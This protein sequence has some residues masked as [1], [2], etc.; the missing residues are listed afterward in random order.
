MPDRVV[1]ALTF[2]AGNTLL[3]C[4]PSPKAIYAEALSRHG[5]AVT[6][7]E[8][9][10][11]FQASWAEMQRQTPPGADR[12]SSFAGG[13]KAWWGAFLREVLGRLGHDAPWQRLLDDLYAAFSRAEVWRAFPEVVP[14]L[15]RL[16]DRGLR[17]AVIS[18][19]DRRL[20]EIL[21]Q[22]ELMPYFEE[23]TV[24]AAEGVEKPN[25]EI[26]RRTLERLGANP[27]ETAHVGD[28]PQEDYHG[29]AAAGL[30][31]VLVDRRQLFVDEGL[32]RIDSLEGVL[33]L[34]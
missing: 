19:W 10:P 16:R 18:N 32:R 15:E 23:V 34:L 13:E 1:A 14:T 5:R 25:P 22:L 30:T 3:Y 12:Y 33:E 26:F 28:S 6:A 24:S 17:L 31:A 9:G 20:P 2:D 21:E 29:A 11:V 4:S 8:V 27:G 7:D